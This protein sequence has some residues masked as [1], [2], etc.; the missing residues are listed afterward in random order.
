MDRLAAQTWSAAIVEDMHLIHNR[1]V[2]TCLCWASLPLLAGPANTE[3]YSPHALE[4]MTSLRAVQR[5]CLHVTSCDVLC[6]VTHL[7]AGNYRRTL[8]QKLGCLP[9][10]DCLYATD[11][12]RQLHVAL[13]AV[14]LQ[15]CRLLSLH[16]ALLA[17]YLQLCCLLQQSN[18]HMQV[19]RAVLMMLQV[20]VREVQQQAA[21]LET[22]QSRQHAVLSHCL[23]VPQSALIWRLLTQRGCW[24]HCWHLELGERVCAVQLSLLP[25]LYP[26]VWLQLGL[27]AIVF[28]L[29]YK[30]KMADKDDHRLHEYLTFSL[31]A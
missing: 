8:S 25:D 17:L 30:K 28:L 27:T 4:T 7:S 19:A 5:V 18:G 10:P 6:H 16:A 1:T 26:A 9:V 3:Q 31:A 29:L 2:R 12:G 11:W 23:A 13:L 20:L 21:S 14:N 24:L 15:H 22:A